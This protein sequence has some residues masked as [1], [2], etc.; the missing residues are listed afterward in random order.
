MGGEGGWNKKE[1]KGTIEEQ[2][3]RER[4]AG[5]EEEKNEIKCIHMI[6]RDMAKKNIYRI[7]LRRLLPVCTGLIYSFYAAGL[8]RDIP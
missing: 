7:E 1:C 3:E 2:K 4:V 6:E 5:K 8:P